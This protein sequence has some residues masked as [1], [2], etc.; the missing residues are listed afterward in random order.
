[1]DRTP[2]WFV[3]QAVSNRDIVPASLSVLRYGFEAYVPVIQRQKRIA[4]RIVDCAAPRF[5]TYIFVKFD[6]DLDPWPELCR[7]SDVRRAYF[8]TVLCNGQGRPSPVP[9]AAMEAI[10]AYRPPSEEAEMPHVYQPGEE[11]ICFVAGLRMQAVF[12]GYQGNR[13]FVKTWIFGRESTVE[14][15]AAELEPLNLDNCSV[16]AAGACK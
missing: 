15:K 16:L 8:E 6:R 9:D 11:V 12:V 3:A 1:M 7:G 14:V 2:H 5:G 10:R 13:Q 4:G